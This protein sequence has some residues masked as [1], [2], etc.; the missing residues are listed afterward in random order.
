MVFAV[1]DVENG[2]SLSGVFVFCGFC[3]FCSNNVKVPLAFLPAA[4]FVLLFI[5]FLFVFLPLLL[6]HFLALRTLR[7]HRPGKLARRPAP[8]WAGILL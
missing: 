1:A 7:G 6:L 8:G 5:L 2:C 4:L 3:R